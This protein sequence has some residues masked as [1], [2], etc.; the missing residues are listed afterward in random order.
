YRSTDPSR[1]LPKRPETQGFPVI[2]GDRHADLR[3]EINLPSITSTY[4]WPAVR[5]G[6]ISSGEPQR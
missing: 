4:R 1:N 6:I 5:W 3:P 2:Q